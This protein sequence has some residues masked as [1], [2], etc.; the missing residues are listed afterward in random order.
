MRVS[1]TWLYIGL[2]LTGFLA[3]VSYKRPATIPPKTPVATLCVTYQTDSE[4]KVSFQAPHS[5]DWKTL[6]LSPEFQS[7]FF[8]MVSNWKDL[9]E[10]AALD[11]H[12]PVS[13]MWAIM[14]S[15]SQGDPRAKSIAG[16]LG[17]M[18]L[19][20]YHFKPGEE[21]YEPRTNIRAGARHLQV[22]RAKVSDLVRAASLYNAG[23][24][25]TNETW[26]AAKRKPAC[27][28]RWGFPA[29]KG[30]IDSVIAANNTFLMMGKGQS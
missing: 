27:V 29:D 8:T 3:L 20:P 18:Q 25:W 7:K 21:P 28:T 23:G 13:W 22:I 6:Q 17:L 12:V 30:F 11:Y 1:D 2:G 9:V 15:E 26:L 4:G 10:E 14:W 5:S 19:M 24:P 16:A